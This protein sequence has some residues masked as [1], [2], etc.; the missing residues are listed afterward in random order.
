MLQLVHLLL[1]QEAVNQ[2]LCSFTTALLPC[3]SLM[4]L[5]RYS[6]VRNELCYCY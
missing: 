5:N 2:E 4:N 6:Y 1:R 3:Y